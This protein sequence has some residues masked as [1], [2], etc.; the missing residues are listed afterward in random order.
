M[1]D[2][3]Q[4]IY[5]Y[6]YIHIPG[7][8]FVSSFSLSQDYLL[9]NLKQNQQY[10]FLNFG[11]SNFSRTVGSCGFVVYVGIIYKPTKETQK[12]QKL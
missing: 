12:K 11:S 9:T 10:P 3:E 7:L 4:P 6:I 2:N 1:I 8:A 5:I